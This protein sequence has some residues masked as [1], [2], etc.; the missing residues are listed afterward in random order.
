MKPMGHTQRAILHL[1]S[2]GEWMRGAEI[3]D[4]LGLTRTNNVWFAIERLRDRGYDIRSDFGGHASRG[5]R[6]V[7]EQRSAA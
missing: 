3:R 2:Q 7:V 6:L 5:Y 1:L 4:H